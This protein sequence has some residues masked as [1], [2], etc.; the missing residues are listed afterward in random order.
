MADPIPPLNGFRDGALKVEIPFSLGFAKAS[1]KNPWGP[2]STFGTPESG[3]S[4]GFADPQNEI[5]YGQVLNG[6][7]TSFLDPRDVVLRSAMYK[8]KGITNP[9]T[10]TIYNPESAI[11]L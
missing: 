10:N 5:G 8:L 7:S 2:P 1:L 9:F 6:M 3:G 11:L 4:F